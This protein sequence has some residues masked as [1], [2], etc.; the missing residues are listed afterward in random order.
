LLPWD[1]QTKSDLES[2]LQTFNELK[3][4]NPTENNVLGCITGLFVIA[5]IAGVL[6]L[7]FTMFFGYQKTE[8]IDWE[9]IP[10]ERPG[11]ETPVMM[12][13]LQDDDFNE[14]YDSISRVTRRLFNTR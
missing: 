4:A 5:V 12:D 2:R 6:Y 11:F 3:K 8:S 1:E 13:S 9:R 14:S 10:T 7:L